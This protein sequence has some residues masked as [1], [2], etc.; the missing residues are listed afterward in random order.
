MREPFID[1]VEAALARQ[2]LADEK[3]S[4]RITGCPNGCAR[5]YA[6]DVGLVGR[7]PGFFALYV[8]GDFE[9]TR[10]SFNL[11]DK[12]AENAVPDTLDVLFGLFA[13]EREAGE[14][15]GDFCHRFG[16][17]ALL[18]ALAQSARKAS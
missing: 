18:S 16:R 13:E 6:G 1:Q 17:D 8:G 9:G 14:G 12:L 4:I 15:F 5:P 2:G 11:V 3:L 10:L 7:M